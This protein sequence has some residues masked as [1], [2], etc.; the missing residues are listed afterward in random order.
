M[1]CMLASAATPCGSPTAH[2]RAQQRTAAP[3][4]ARPRVCT[5]RPAQALADTVRA[6]AQLSLAAAGKDFHSQDITS[7]QSDQAGG[8]SGGGT[9][10]AAAPTS[11]TFLDGLITVNDPALYVDGSSKISNVISG[12]TVAAQFISYAPCLILTQPYGFGVFANGVNI[13]PTG[14]YVVPTAFNVEPQG[15]NVAPTL[16]YVGPV[17]KNIAPQGFN[18]APALISVAPVYNSVGT[19]G[20]DVSG[21]PRIKTVTL[22]RDGNGEVM[23]TYP[24]EAGSGAANADSSSTTS[25]T[26]PGGG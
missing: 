17:A 21:D 24:D 6:R 5:G 11:K 22:P 23:V 19:P 4:S 3:N 9:A 26:V 7:T 18:V 8:G 20:K 25:A 1:A 12:L 13:Q 15:F 2:G 16:I 14:V 10:A